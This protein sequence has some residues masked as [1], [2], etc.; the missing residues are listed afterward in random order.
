MGFT[1]WNSHSFNLTKEGT[2]VQQYMNFT[3]MSAEDRK[4]QREDL[5]VLDDIFAMGTVPP[6]TSQEACA[7]FTLPA[8]SRLVT[9]SSHTHKYGRDF[10][11]WL[12]TQ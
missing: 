6:F 3:Y 1:I 7:T 10:R 9:L 12:P 4:C 11:I 2:T 5:T 8:G